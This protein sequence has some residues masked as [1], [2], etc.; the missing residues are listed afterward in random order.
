VELALEAGLLTEFYNIKKGMWCGV[1]THNTY[2]E[3][4]KIMEEIFF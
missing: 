2:Y 1:A 3:Q 4:L